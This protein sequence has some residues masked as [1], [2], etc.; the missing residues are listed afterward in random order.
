MQ[1]PQLLYPFLLT[2]QSYIGHTFDG[3]V[4]L[5]QN[6]EPLTLIQPVQVLLK[7]SHSS[8]IN[9][10]ADNNIENIFSQYNENKEELYS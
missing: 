7:N 1:S 3:I 9:P 4:S 8:Q 2:A 10:Q 5:A 6:V